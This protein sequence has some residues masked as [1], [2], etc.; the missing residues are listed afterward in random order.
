MKRNFF[1]RLIFACL[2]FTAFGCGGS[3]Q[4]QPNPPST[5]KNPAAP[6]TSAGTLRGFVY[7]KDPAVHFDPAG[8]VVVLM[9][10]REAVMVNDK[11]EFI[12]DNAAPGT[13]HLFAF[14]PGENLFSSLGE[15]LVEVQKEKK[16]NLLL[17]ESGSLS[18]KIKKVLEDETTKPASSVPVM[19]SA[20]LSFYTRTDEKGLFNFPLLPPDT[21]KVN[22]LSTESE[23]KGNSSVLVEPDKT[24]AFDLNLK[25]V[26]EGTKNENLFS[27]SG[28][29]IDAATGKPVSKAKLSVGEKEDTTD[30]QG[31]FKFLS[32]PSVPYTVKVQAEKYLPLALNNIVP[33]SMNE[34]VELFLVPAKEKKPEVNVVCDKAKYAKSDKIVLSVNVKNGT[35]FPLPLYFTSGKIFEVNVFAGDKKVWS[36]SSDKEYLPLFFKMVAVPG[37]ELS[38]KTQ[39]PASQLSVG[40]Y[41]VFAEVFSPYVS[42]SE[43]PATFD[44]VEKEEIPAPATDKNKKTSNKMTERGTK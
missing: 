15:A 6:T 12:F 18:G 35:K 39:V 31:I 2:I 38:F 33:S 29:L 7:Y 1:A 24:Q 41:Q 27:F 19:A 37:K 44:V 25:P 36:S 17:K 40:T 43:K 20:A 14:K 10:T 21:Y 42:P 11:G 8:T 13:H 5:A 32:I 9:T 30:D 23:V 26:K 34:S 16:V 4:P 22:A 28:K 3:N